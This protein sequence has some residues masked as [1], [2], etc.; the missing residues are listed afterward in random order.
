M[1]TELAECV[2]RGT[3]LESDDCPISPDGYYREEDAEDVVWKQES[4]SVLQTQLAEDGT[5]SVSGDLDLKVSW[6]DVGYDE[7][8]KMEDTC[9]PRPFPPL[10]ISPAPVRL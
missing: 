8:E 5:V 6:T 1:V 10:S 4:E 3:S 9:T 2:E 7:G